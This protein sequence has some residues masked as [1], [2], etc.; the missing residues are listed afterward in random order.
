MIEIKNKKDCCGCGSCAQVCPVNCI[1][2]IEDREGFLYPKVEKEKCVDCN[3]CIKGCPIQSIYSNLDN[4]VKPIA[5]AA[6]VKE[7][8]IRLSSSSG[9]IFS[10]LVHIILRENGVVFGAAFDSNMSVHHI[11]IEDENELYKLQGSKYI[12]S[13]IDDTFQEVSYFLKRGRKVLYSGTACQI[14]GLKR[15]LG[16][17]YNNLYTVDV[18]CH[19]VPSPKVWRKYLVS[20]EQLAGSQVKKVYFRKKQTGWKTFSI[21]LQFNNSKKYE[22]VFYKD[23]YMLMFLK[24][25]CL[26]PSCYNCKFKSLSRLSDIT[27]GDFWGIENIAPEMDNNKGTSIVLIQSDKGKRLFHDISNSIEIKSIDAKTALPDTFDSMRSVQP[28]VKR[29]DFFDQL[30]TTSIQKLGKMVQPSLFFK[31]KSVTLFPFR[32]VKN[33]IKKIDKCLL[34]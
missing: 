4:K 2:M 32:M 6:F 24:N 16:R 17:D 3:L 18:L 25:I 29:N 9:G 30:D 14:A 31:M 10:V 28:H 11:A 33:L 1:I 34:K 7:D 22:Q 20:K 13:R 23:V 27:L 15:Y 12:Q 5:Y 19:G 8:E 21:E 26:R